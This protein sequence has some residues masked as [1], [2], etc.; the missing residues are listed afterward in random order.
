MAVLGAPIVIDGSHG[1]GGGAL[2]RTALAMS[3]L[4][5][6]P[7]RVVDIRGGTKYPGLNSEDVTLLRALA[8]SCGAE[9][10]GGVPG[11]SSLSFLPTRRPKG[12]NERFDIA[13]AYDGPGF[14][15][16]L[17]ILN[18]L[19]PLMARTGVYS[20]LTAHGET[21]GNHMLTYDY[22]ANVTLQAYRRMGLYAFP[23][24]PVA[25]F[26]RGSRGEV[27]LEIEPSEILGEIG[28]AHV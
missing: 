16:A 24:M 20:K 12:L 6:Q 11:E 5:Q 13:E 15:N 14:A 23:E 28:R 1:E 3:A 4:T 8:L 25:G 9:V 19:V 17:V 10:L 21:Y 22:F 26:G 7:L 2:L 27:R 18:S